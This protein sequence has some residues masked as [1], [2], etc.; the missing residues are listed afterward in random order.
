MN[1]KQQMQRLN[2]IGIALSSE[3]NLNRLLERIMAEARAFT[4]ADAG[5]LY[6][7]QAESR[8]LKYEILQNDTLGMQFGGISGGEIPW[9]PLLPLYN[10]DGSSN[11]ANVSASVAISGKT[12]NIPDVYKTEEFDF[13]RMRKADQASGYCCKSMLV[14]PMRDHEDEIIGVLQLINAMDARRQAIPFS[15]AVEDLIASLASQ[16]AVAITN[17]R[18]IQGMEALFGAFVKVMATAIDEKAHY[19][20]GHIE[21]VALL[22]MAIS[23]SISEA[24][25][26]PYADVSFSEEELNELRIAAWM[27]DVG[28]VTTPEWVVDKAN[29][30]EAVSDRVKLIRTRFGII[31]EQMRVLALERKV[32]L[33]KKG[34]GEAELNAVDGELEES[35]QELGEDLDFVIRVN[36]PE[37]F[38]KDEYLERLQQIAQKTFLE[39]GE[40]TPYLTEDE[41]ENLSIRKGSLTP[42]QI[43]IIRNHAAVTLKM[44]EQIPFTKKLKNVPRFAG[45]HHEML[46]GS[47]Y[48]L[49][50]A[51]DQLPL[52]SRIL[53]VA[54]VFEALSARD[55]PYKKAKTVEETMRILGFMVKDGHLDPDVVDLL[56][57]EKVY[58]KVPSIRE[59]LE[60]AGK[61]G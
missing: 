37:E 61:Q 10:P 24:D 2:E 5:T 3:R 57:K 53:A 12:V 17:V 32:A 13:S 8:T 47:G 4:H 27:H 6:L 54:D 50:I 29:K 34:S 59:T 20:R 45:A 7:V 36:T 42:K 22:T 58:N 25:E 44:L 31:R 38:M 26:G 55:R 30:L 9:D 51:G 49:G 46:D 23:E 11:N 28:K 40:T 48:P 60:A 21:R 56:I 43:G 35:I 16:A 33:L 15:S 19:T 18:L 41:L 52:Q 1:L 39:N 14:L